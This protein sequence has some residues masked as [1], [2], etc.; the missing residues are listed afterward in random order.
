MTI[1]KTINGNEAVLSLEGWLDTVES[2]KLQAELDNLESNIDSLVLDLAGLQYT[3]SSGIRQIVSAYKKMKGA[4]VIR[5]TSE[6]VM[7]VFKATGLDKKINF[8]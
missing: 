8:E 3:S 5:N 4:L 7:G 6:G 1:K 2:P